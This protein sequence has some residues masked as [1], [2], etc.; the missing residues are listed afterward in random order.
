[1]PRFTDE[2]L[3]SARQTDL[4][5]LLRRCGE[6]LKRSGGEFRWVYRDGGG[7]HDSVTI[8]GNS[9]FDHKREIGGDAIGFLQEFDGLS[10]R[11]A[12]EELLDLDGYEPLRSLPEYT[13][14]QQNKKDFALPPR[15]Q[16][17][18]RL[19]AYLCKTRGIKPEIVTH[20]VRAGTLY[21]DAEYHN[22]VFIATDEDGTP[23]GGM[24][25]TTASHSN[26]RQTIEGSD[27]AFAFHHRGESNQVYV[28]EAAVDMLSFL[29]VYGENW[30]QHSYLTLDGV[31]D[32]PLMR[33]LEANAEVNAI[34][35]SLDN[36]DAGHKATSR[37]A[38]NLHAKGY[39]L[40]L[41]C[42]PRGKDWNEDLLSRRNAPEPQSEPELQL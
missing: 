42:E 36:D 37:I 28:F 23:C 11:D 27:T 30:Q 19:F 39:E 17:Q 21:E 12:V 9:W 31:S 26:F 5:A 25:K 4:E 3:D 18:H 13:A 34:F 14:T 41:V 24:K 20:F 10:F 22:A 2:Q 32:K 7:E 29:C 38:E 40:V 35:L 1:M 8:R 16:N 33:F 15:A 6:T